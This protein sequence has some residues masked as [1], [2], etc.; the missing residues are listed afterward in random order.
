VQLRHLD[1]ATVTHFPH[2][3]GSIQIVGAWGW[4]AV[5]DVVKRLVI[6]RTHEL[7]EGLRSGATEQLATFEGQVPMRPNTFWLWKEAERLYGRHL[8]GIA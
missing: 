6:H 7:R 4:A 3:P 2:A 1:D 5:P 8:P